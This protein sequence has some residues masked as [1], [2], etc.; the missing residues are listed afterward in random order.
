MEIE[1]QEK[2]GKDL[3][4]EKSMGKAQATTSSTEQELIAMTEVSD[5]PYTSV[6]SCAEELDLG[7]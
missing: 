2:T 3:E 7:K 1:E 6:L 4:R 5:F